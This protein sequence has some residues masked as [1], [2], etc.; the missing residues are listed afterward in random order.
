MKSVLIISPNTWGKLLISKHNYAIE[1]T[2][3]GYKVFFMNPPNQDLKINQYSVY[4]INEFPNLYL[5]N[6]KISNNRFLDYLRLRLGFTE[7]LDFSLYRLIK[8]ICNRESIQ[9][10]QI[11]NFDPN[12]HGFLYKYPSEFKIF[13]VV[14]QISQKSHL[15]S[16]RN[17]DLVVSVT[18]VIL[19]KY[20]EVNSKKLLLNHG[21]NSLF[22]NQAKKNLSNTSNNKCIRNVGYVGNLIIRFINYKVL[23]Q[24]V[25]NNPDITF[26]FWGAYNTENNNLLGAIDS[27]VEH[28]IENFKKNKNVILYGLKVQA[29]ILESINNM[30]AFLMCYDIEN[31]PNEGANSHKILEYL[32]T[33]KVIIAN[34][35]LDYKNSDLFPMLKDTDTNKLIKLFDDVINNVEYYNAEELQRKRLNFALASTYEQNIIKIESTL[36]S[37]NIY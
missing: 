30:D 24:I 2:K 20:S 10:E 5:I 28:N 26:H 35:V 34:R 17:I 19:N 32:S 6:T 11:W 13:F 12:L 31:D 36:K 23:N 21:L 25:Q 14:D 1:M 33:G 8:K 3:L 29:E 4:P 18:S 15:R 22:V 37:K 7:I 16:A 27:G 9:F